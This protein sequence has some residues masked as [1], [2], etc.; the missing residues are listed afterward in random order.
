MLFSFD[1]ALQKS[2]GPVPPQPPGF[3]ATDKE[4]PMSILQHLINKQAASKNGPSK[5][6]DLI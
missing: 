6:L 1:T 3:D 4:G 5:L 2:G